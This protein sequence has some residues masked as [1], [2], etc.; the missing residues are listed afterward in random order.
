MSMQI[1]SVAS[2]QIMPVSAY[3]PPSILINLRQESEEFFLKKGLLSYKTF[4]NSYASAVGGNKSI[5]DFICQYIRL[6]EEAVVN[7]QLQD[8]RISEK[9]LIIKSVF[10]VMRQN[11]T[12]LLNAGVEITPELFHAT[13]AGFLIGKLK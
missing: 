5:Q 11:V 10:E 4:K 13:T 2:S 3:A 9:K 6:L 8:D 7:G 12:I 1:N